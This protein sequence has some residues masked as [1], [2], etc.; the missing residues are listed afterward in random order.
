MKKITTKVG[1]IGPICKQ[2][3]TKKCTLCFVFA[4]QL[5]NR[6]SK[7]WCDLERTQKDEEN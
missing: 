7:N 5:L 1:K 6:F 4:P 2:L 3:V